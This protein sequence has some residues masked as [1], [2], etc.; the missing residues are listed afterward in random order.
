M[1]AE[2]WLTMVLLCLSGSLIFWLPYWADI[3]YVPMQSAFGFSNT[4]M[5][6]LSG[7]AGFTALIS[8]VP[9]GWLADRFP[10][11]QLMSTALVI[12]AMGGFVFARIPPFDVCL[13]LYGLWGASAGLI[14]WSALIKATR[15]WAP[16]DEQG[17][18]FGFL[19]GGRS[20]T[21]V[22]ST[23]VLLAVFAYLGAESAALSRTIQLCSSA[24]IVLAVLVWLVMKDQPTSGRKIQG[25]KSGFSLATMLVVIKMPTVWL[26]SIVIM[27]AN[28]GMW[29]TIYFTP[30][31][32][33]I[34]D[35]G[36]VWGGAVGAGKYALAA[37]AAITAGFIADRI[38]TSR[39]VVGL[40][41]VMTSGFL[42]FAWVPG[43]PGL[44][45]MML[46]NAGLIA[47][48]VFG[49]RG[50]YYALL[51]Q[52]GV[53][54]AVTG[55]AVGMVSV[56]GYTPDALA[57]VVSGLILDA[58]PGEEGYRLLFLLIASLGLI[59]VVAAMRIHRR[60]QASQ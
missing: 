47:I 44:V 43:A 57:P 40:F 21:D 24:L 53:P 48:V 31:A 26:L 60:V 20:I 58:F 50:I 33:D 16:Q 37:F 51:E 12:S 7:T 19:E 1:I 52:G 22:T 15:K 46:V 55:T 8:Y 59:G 27:S 30:Y 13:V 42:L 56:I 54:I 4:Q 35:L 41:L 45:L 23:A 39:A 38:G 29:G 3:F 6:M 36:D 10:A 17:R 49:V 32:T 2:K 11:R 9:G 25:A 14:F 18:A 5:G 28:W 34:Y